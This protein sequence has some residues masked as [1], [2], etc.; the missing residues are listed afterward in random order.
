MN[1]MSNLERKEGC[2]ARAMEILGTKWTALIIRD[3]LVSPR[4]FCELEKSV[5][6]VNPRTLSKRLTILEENGIIKKSVFHEVPPRSEYTLTQKGRDLL[7]II[8]K[9]SAWGAKYNSVSV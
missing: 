9:M 7:P 5:G 2:I 8:E 4:G 6:G 1:H 3:L